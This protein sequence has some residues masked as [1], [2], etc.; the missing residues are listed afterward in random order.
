M[1]K[2]ILAGAVALAVTAPVSSS[3]AAPNWNNVPATDIVVFYPGVSPMEWILGDLR[4]DRVRHGGGRGFKQGDTCL[5]CHGDEAAEMGK[6]IVGGEKLEPM[7]IQGKAGSIPV[8]VQA[9]HDG[10][11]LYL[12]FSWTQP[13]ASSGK[14]LDE[15]NPMKIA[16][17]L[18]GG[19]VDMG[20]RGGCWA[21]CHADS[22]TMPDGKD[23]KRKYV[24]GASLDGGVYFD[25]VQWRSGENKAADGHVA[26]TRVMEGGTALVSAEGKLD[27]N[28]WS[29]VFTRKLAGGTGDVKL[30]PGKTYNFG[31]AIHDSHSAGRFHHVSLGYK[32]GLD[33]KADIT[34]AK[35]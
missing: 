32:L 16:F 11:N 30:E 14:K 29:V 10:Q 20:D 17:M 25:L 18:D 5:A 9:S 1:K 35:Q 15:K 6:K 3:A 26:E 28:T 34:A 22:R 8:K 33:A 2:A 13:A 27:G 31:F 7:P 12:R 24:K 4:V 19:K 21:S 23:D